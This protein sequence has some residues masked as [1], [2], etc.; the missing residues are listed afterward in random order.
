MN[1]HMGMRGITC[2]KKTNPVSFP[3]KGGEAA[4]MVQ[5]RYPNI[6]SPRPLENAGPRSKK[7]STCWLILG[8]GWILGITVLWKVSPCTSSEKAKLQ[9][10]SL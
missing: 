9:Y 8:F 3:R 1:V 4:D 6:K 7:R 5:K 2:V 10:R